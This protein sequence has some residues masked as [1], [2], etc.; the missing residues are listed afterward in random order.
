M[1][2]TATAGAADR[3]AGYYYPKLT[4]E[5]TYGARAQIMQTESRFEPTAVSWAGARGLVQLMPATAEETARREKV[6]YE[7]SRLFE[8]AYNLRLGQ[9]YLSRLLGRWDRPTQGLRDGVPALAVPSYNAGP[10]AVDRWLKERGDW[11]LDLWVEA[12]PYDETRHYVQTVLGRWWAYRWIYGEGDPAER[13]P[14]L[15]LKIPSRAP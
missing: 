14:Y 3:H 5:E 11:D 6:K 12:I 7:R 8:P 4:S 1:A 13:A 15:P 10:G 9:A 2:F